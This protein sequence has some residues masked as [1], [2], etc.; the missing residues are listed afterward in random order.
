MNADVM[1]LARLFDGSESL[2]AEC[3]VTEELTKRESAKPATSSVIGGRLTLTGTITARA[4]MASPSV[5]QRP[6]ERVH[7]S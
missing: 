7:S 3:R 2:F 6:T 1:G 4:S 5:P